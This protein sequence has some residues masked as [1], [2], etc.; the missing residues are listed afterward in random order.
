MRSKREEAEKKM[1]MREKKEQIEPFEELPLPVQ[2]AISNLKEKSKEV[3]EKDPYPHFFPSE[4]DSLLLEFGKKAI[5]NHEKKFLS[6][7]IVDQLY[8]LP[9]ANST[10]SVKK[11]CFQNFLLKTKN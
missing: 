7:K 2:E 4:L 6:T 1:K 9:F 5:D 10:L 8:F 11:L 3:L